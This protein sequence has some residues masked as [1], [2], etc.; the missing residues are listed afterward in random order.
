MAQRRS[1][2][3]AEA[4]EAHDSVVPILDEES[5]TARPVS[6]GLDKTKKENSAKVARQKMQDF[7]A[8]ILSS[9][10]DISKRMLDQFSVDGA[11]LAGN[12]LEMHTD[13]TQKKIAA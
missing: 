9:F 11:P 13:L 12:P 2:E 3:A 8:L 1:Y 10:E 7:D 5:E 6:L 4:L